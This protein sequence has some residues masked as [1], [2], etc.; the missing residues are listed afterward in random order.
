M[1]PTPQR[2]NN[3]NGDVPSERAVDRR[4][5]AVELVAAAGALQRAARLLDGSDP[6]VD[7][8]RTGFG[9]PIGD[10]VTARQLSA[11]HAI[12]RRAELSKEE[13]TKMVRALGKEEPA[14]LT[15]S[16]AS[17][18]IDKLRALVGE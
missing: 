16:E 9:T 10:R 3:G 12:A 11:I 8:S 5:L 17:E 7:S 15:R 4:S 1:K 6:S 2:P 13:L 14:G 18:L